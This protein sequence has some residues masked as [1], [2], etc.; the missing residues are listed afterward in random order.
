MFQ[1]IGIATVSVVGLFAVYARKGHW[2]E[3]CVAF[4]NSDCWHSAEEAIKK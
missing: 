1:V 3:S 4:H 2:I